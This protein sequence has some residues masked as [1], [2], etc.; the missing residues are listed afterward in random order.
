MLIDSPVLPEELEALPGVFGHAGFEVD[1]LLATHADWDHL[2][3]P[4]AYPGASLGLGEPSLLRVRAEPGAAQRELREWD[5]EHYVERPSPLSLGSVQSLPVPGKLELGGEEIE[6]HIADGHSSDGT[7][8][9][10]GWLGVLCCGD[11]LSD[12]EIP[13]IS[14]SGSLEG[15]RSTLRRLR[16]LVERAEAVVPGHG[17]VL[18]RTRALELLA[19]DEAYC[20]ALAAGGVAPLPAGRDTPRQR[21]LHRENVARA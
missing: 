19:E 9:L 18:D 6:L 5:A 15:Y 16:A 14:E 3:G 21:E 8:Y 4:L 12:V 13:L 1:A 11:Y 2:L 20:E 7:I 10:A 17:S